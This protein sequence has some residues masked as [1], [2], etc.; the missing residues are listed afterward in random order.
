MPPSMVT[1]TAEEDRCAS[2]QFDPLRASSAMPTD[3]WLLV[4]DCFAQKMCSIPRPQAALSG[5]VHIGL[6]GSPQRLLQVQAKAV[7]EEENRLFVEWLKCENEGCGAE[8]PTNA[9][10]ISISFSVAGER[11]LMLPWNLN[12]SR[13]ASVSSR[14]TMTHLPSQTRVHFCQ[15]N[16]GKRD[17]SVLCLTVLRFLTLF[18][19]SGRGQWQTAEDSNPQYGAALMLAASDYLLKQNWPSWSSRLL[20][21]ANFFLLQ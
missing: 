11:S 16:S 10:A 15:E 6:A 3:V 8:L 12:C 18:S 17:A 19:G 13:T 20:T 1:P 4:K 7:G 2:V 21:A 9:D 14:V 5:K